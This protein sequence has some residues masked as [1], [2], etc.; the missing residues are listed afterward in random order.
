MVYSPDLQTRAIGLAA[1]LLSG[2][3]WASG[4][5]DDTVSMPAAAV[6][7]IARLDRARMQGAQ[8]E[9][10]NWLTH[11][12]TY[13]EQR[14]SPLDRIH[15]DN[16]GR[17]G[18]VWHFDFEFDGTYEAT[19]LVVDGVLYVTAPWSIVHAIDARTGQLIWRYDPG[20]RPQPGSSEPRRVPPLCC[21]P[22]NRGVAAW[23]GKIYVGTLDGR[24]VA[25][26][27]RTG[28]RVWERQT[29][30]RD[31]PYSIT[32]APRVVRGMVLIGNGG[33]D[34]GV[35]GYVSAYDASSGALVWRFYTVPDGKTGKADPEALRMAADTWPGGGRW[36]QAGG[37]GTV[38]DSISYD[39]DSNLVY[40]GVGNG[41]PL[42]RY[43]RNP[44]GGDNLFLASIVALDADTGEYAWH[45][46]TTPRE[47]F[48]YT[49]TQ[50][51]ILADL[52]IDGRRRQVLM[53]APKN[54]FFYVLDRKTGGFISA[55][56][57]ATVNWALGVDAETGRPIDS[58]QADYEREPR[59][60]Q[61]STHG[62][63]SWHSM[64]FHPETGLVYLPVREDYSVLTNSPNS[65]LIIGPGP[66]NSPATLR[67][68]T[69]GAALP[70]QAS[71]LS[72][73]DPVAQRER[74][75]VNHP[76]I[77]N[78]GV[79]ATA[80]NL[81][82]QGTS[83]GTFAAYRADDGKLLW[84]TPVQT[85]VVA[86]PVSYALDGEQYVALLVGHGSA[87]IQVDGEPRRVKSDRALGRLLV[88]GLDGHE[89]LPALRPPEPPPEPPVSKASDE[90]IAQGEW[91]YLK[92]CSTCHGRAAVNLSPA[93][94]L[95]YM[96][97]ETHHEFAAI[98]LEGTRAD[99]AMPR[100]ARWLDERQ[101]EAIRAYVIR[102]ANDTR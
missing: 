65:R 16:V 48:D 12:R 74:W 89:E 90:T 28:E 30:D 66:G 37:G 5:G 52:E 24:L 96:S 34:F 11:G 59:V 88:F 77:L 81:V 26:E 86:A 40:V 62:A 78:G 61:P 21:G 36:L 71:R 70:Q 87:L 43:K 99:K 7:G 47:G 29:T 19:P 49:A 38:W 10:G 63:H 67:K 95:R 35:R 98:L 85:G 18:L 8:G 33:A 6:D 102:R 68:L 9:P 97:R 69:G 94:D 15:A 72:A 25:L 22:V 42:N 41:S 82:F 46:Q 51:M 2:A 84:Q 31:A 17:L 50:Q 56:P 53:Q 76:W 75:R 79:L 73:W 91:L 4:C 101:V 32:G 83:H 60:I 14:F 13:D 45:F 64:A 1:L 55:A 80:G 23:M 92:F 27:A 3:L 20:L 100:F 44:G 93:P 58:P 39:P 54:G 57:F